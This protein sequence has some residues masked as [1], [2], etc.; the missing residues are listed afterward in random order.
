ML[1]KAFLSMGLG[2]ID[3]RMSYMV[4]LVLEKAA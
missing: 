3:M 4:L 1:G 2:K